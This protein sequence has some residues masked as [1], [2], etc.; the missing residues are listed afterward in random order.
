M[1]I[2]SSLLPKVTRQNVE[3]LL[4]AGLLYANVGSGRF[5]KASRD[6]A[7]KRWKRDAS[8]LRLPI[9]CGMY[10]KG[11]ITEAHFDADGVLC[12]EYFKLLESAPTIRPTVCADAF[13]L[14]T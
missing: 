2:H 9:K 5:W 7:T 3:L 10:V 6:G 13:A 4:D 12:A 11:Q 8:R 1:S 14:A